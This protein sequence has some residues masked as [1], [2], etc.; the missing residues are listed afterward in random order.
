MASHKSVNLV[1]NDLESG[2]RIETIRN[3]KKLQY[4]FSLKE[5]WQ[6]VKLYLI[7][8]TIISITFVAYTTISSRNASIIAQ[9]STEIHENYP[10]LVKFILKVGEKKV[11]GCA[12]FLIR[13]KNNFEYRKKNT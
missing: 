12:G 4:Q 8:V 5:C 1:L 10:H 9:E 3:T 7:L 11:Q 6:I 13:R 2:N